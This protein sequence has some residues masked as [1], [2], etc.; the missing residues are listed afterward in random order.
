L[1]REFIAPLETPAQRQLVLGI[2]PQ[3]FAYYNRKDLAQQAEV[4]ADQH[5]ATNADRS[6]E[7]A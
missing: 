1:F 6:A 4:L 2:L 3:F 7:I 5:S